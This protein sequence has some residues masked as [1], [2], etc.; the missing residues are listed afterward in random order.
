VRR[1]FLREMSA[2]FATPVFYT[3]AGVFLCLSGLFFFHEVASV[4]I[5]A[6]RMAQTRVS[7]G[8]SMNELL[9]GPLFSDLSTLVIFFCPLISMGLFKTGKEYSPAYIGSWVEVVSAKYLAA[10]T[11]ML[12]M[13][14]PTVL[15]M[16]VL[17]FFASLDR[18]V[19]LSSYLGL[20]LLAGAVLAMGIWASCLTRNGAT[21]AALTLGMA[22]FFWT[23]GWFAPLFPEGR[24]GSLLRELSLSSHLSRFFQGVI[25]LSDMLYFIE[26]AVFFLV[27]SLLALNS[28]RDRG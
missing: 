21:A 23:T 26:M 15:L 19:L 27:L 13:V 20:V 11:A 24:T 16:V 3:L 2:F 25:G 12:A 4:S 10:L 18:G 17:A 5:L 14:L 7:G 8:F 1:V 28:G 9:L 22:L 6:S